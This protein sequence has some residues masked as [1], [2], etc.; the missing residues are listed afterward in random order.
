MSVLP[1]T[2]QELHCSLQSLL[3]VLNTHNLNKASELPQSQCRIAER[4]KSYCRFFSGLKN[5]VLKRIL[6]P[7]QLCRCQ[8]FWGKSIPQGL[9]KVLT[10]CCQTWKDLWLCTVLPFLREEKQA[11]N[12]HQCQKPESPSYS[13][14]QKSHSPDFPVKHITCKWVSLSVD[15]ISSMCVI[16]RM[17]QLPA[18]SKPD[19]GIRSCKCCLAAI[20]MYVSWKHHRREARLHKIEKT[21]TSL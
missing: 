14:W 20:I 16:K 17:K 3:L 21:M 18:I 12:A 7:K 13:L 1:G 4:Q 8:Y 11:A 10:Y 2:A 5:K 15:W 19:V 9:Y 6:K